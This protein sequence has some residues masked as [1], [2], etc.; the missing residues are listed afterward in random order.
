MSLISVLIALAVEHFYK[1]IGELRQFGW[2]ARYHDM[3]F[4]KLEGQPFRDGPLGIVLILG[5]IVFAVWLVNAMLAGVA[6]IFS[7]IFTVVVLIYC[8]GPRDLE[9]DMLNFSQAIER[10]DTEAAEIMAGEFLD[11]PP[12]DNSTADLI[13][14]VEA[15]ILIHANI[16]VL[17]VLLW[18]MLL[19]PVGAVLFRLSCLLKSRLAT[20]DTAY[21]TAARDLY[22]ILMWL[23]ARM[24]V[25]GFAL[26]GSFIDT[27][28]NWSNVSDMWRRDSDEFIVI[29][30][31]GAIRHELDAEQGEC[32]TGLVCIHHVMALVK[33]TLL[34]WVAILAILT[35]TGLVF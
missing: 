13:K 14:H 28:S 21:A 6:I 11:T 19:G 9:K 30:G 32:E 29:S 10:G 20:E 17:G 16:R 18:F 4:N 8:M 25:I 24:S 26:T 1:Q 23:P 31:L 12:E 2:F 7:F 15:G 3:L 35:L 33:R 22:R 34:V 27:M 5:S